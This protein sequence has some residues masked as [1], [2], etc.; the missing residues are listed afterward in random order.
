MTACDRQETTWALY[1][2]ESQREVADL[3]HYVKR[4][5]KKS[6]TVLSQKMFA[7]AEYLMFRADMDPF[8]KQSFL[9]VLEAV[10]LHRKTF[11]EI[12]DP[13]VRNAVGDCLK[14]YEVVR[15]WVLS[16]A[17]TDQRDIES[18]ECPSLD[19]FKR[20][21]RSE[22]LR[23]QSSVAK[24]SYNDM[25]EIYRYVLES[26]PADARMM[27][28]VGDGT[29]LKDSFLSQMV[30]FLKKQRETVHVVS[31]DIRPTIFDLQAEAVAEYAQ[32]NVTMAFHCMDGR[33]TIF[34][35]NVFDCTVASFMID[36]CDDHLSLIRELGRVTKTEGLIC[37]S[38]HHL[39][40]ES[41]PDN[42][43]HNFADLHHISGHPATFASACEHAK[44]SGLNIKRQKENSHA[45]ALVLSGAK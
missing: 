36:D 17:Q 29:P 27:F 44:N 8:Y 13:A 18:P 45:W 25:C 39:D 24:K 34:S 33:R 15:N 23:L 31:V 38:G 30:P 20:M 41:P 21:T 6:Q 12:P 5:D 28:N 1:C 11:G 10:R 2:D 43:V 35:S 16:E 42:L 37:L 40:D 19:D 9:T 14:T 32:S 7:A 26:I 3:Y 4:R 22:R